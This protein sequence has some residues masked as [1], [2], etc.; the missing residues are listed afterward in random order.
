V[1]G[2]A[3]IS[4]RPAIRAGETKPGGDLVGLLAKRNEFDGLRHLHAAVAGSYDGDKLDR[5]HLATGTVLAAVRGLELNP[6]RVRVDPHALHRANLSAN[7]PPLSPDFGYI[8]LRFDFL[9]KKQPDIAANAPLDR[10][11]ASTLGLQLPPLVGPDKRPINRVLALATPAGSKLSYPFLLHTEHLYDYGAD[12][13]PHGNYLWARDGV[14][15]RCPAAYLSA[16]I[17]MALLSASGPTSIQLYLVP[18]E[19]TNE[20]ALRRASRVLPAGKFAVDLSPRYVEEQRRRLDKVLADA[21]EDLAKKRGETYPIRVSGGGCF[22]TT[23]ACE[24]LGLADDCWEL[25]TLRRFRDTA[26]QRL[27]SGPEDIARYYREAPAILAALRRRA[28]SPRVFHALYWRWILPCALLAALG[29][30]RL[31]HHT[32]RAMMRR[33]ALSRPVARV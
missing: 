26:L 9:A 21:R 13:S 2:A 18:D 30:D 20:V 7:L 16:E 6:A 12:D 22:I 28:D 29:A 5:L 8:K 32:Y 19:L 1:L 31:C 11:G 10:V 23:A 25:R 15:V 27:P 17:R 14:G 3:G 4:L 33:L 24:G